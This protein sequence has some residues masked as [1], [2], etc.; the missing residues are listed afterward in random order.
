MTTTTNEVPTITTFVRRDDMPSLSDDMP[1]LSSSD[2]FTTPSIVVPSSNDN[3]YIQRQYNP[4]GSVFIAVGCIVGFI[5]LAFIIYHL[6]RSM[7]ASR[8]AKRS[9]TGTQNIE[10]KRHNSGL[11]GLTPTGTSG[12]STLNT[13]YR[14]SV[15]KL[16][17]LNHQ[18]NK[19][20]F[21][22]LDVGDNSTLYASEA[23]ATRN[24]L[25]NMFISPTA[26]VMAHKRNK[27]T[28]NL[29]SLGGSTSNFNSVLPAPATNRHSQIVPSLY[30]NSDTN[31][32]DMALSSKQ[33]E[34]SVQPR[35]T[36][37][38]ANKT[39]IPSVYLDDLIEK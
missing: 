8:L 9:W 26:E 16:P 32:S 37:G 17:L 29:S 11:Y 19:S 28:S 18:H 3:P 4:S 34:A 15:A 24:D 6:F 21:S 2:S 5:L 39:T 10:E 27:S 31:N 36:P 38:R 23:G 12:L 14:S 20:S 7:R 33:S 30:I 25:T 35:A 13:E 1:T 22:G